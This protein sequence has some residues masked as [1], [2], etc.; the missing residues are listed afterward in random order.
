MVLMKIEAKFTKK[1]SKSRDRNFF[2]FL[3][4]K[5]FLTVCLLKKGGADKPP[6]ISK[7]AKYRQY[8]LGLIRVYLC[9]EYI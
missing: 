1:R 9:R 7:R 4:L 5:V 3:A 8:Y 2:R 6:A